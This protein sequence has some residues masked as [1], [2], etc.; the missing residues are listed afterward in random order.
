MEHAMIR[1]GLVAFIVTA[2]VVTGGEGSGPTHAAG[3]PVSIGL[4]ADITGSASAYGVSIR[5]G[6][7]LASD[8]L[9]A[10]GGVNGHPISLD[11]GD[12]ASSNTQ[13]ISLYQQY[14]ADSHVLGIIGPTLSSEAFKAD[15]IAQHAGLPVI[16]TSN[17]VAGVTAMGNY[18]FRMSLGEADVVPLTIKTAMR[19]FHFKNVAIL[20]GNDNAFTIGDGQVFAAVTKALKLHVLD[21]ET[22]A[23]GDK[24]FKVQL[25]KIKGMHPDAIFVGA[26]APE[27]VLIL[28]QARQLGL[29]STVRII[30]GN[31]FNSPAV[32]SGAGAAAEGTI[33]GT[34]WFANSKSMANQRFVTAYKAKYGKAPDQFAAQA[35]DGVNIMAAGIKLANT[36]SSRAAVRD[37]LTKIKNVPVVTGATGT[38]S[39]LPSRDA[40]E[41]GTVQIIQ[42]GKFVQ[43]S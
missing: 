20:Y 2:G 42:G 27:A 4:V 18:I 7:Q 36:V 38:F 6:A 19:H 5:N 21:T 10:A 1:A 29:P 26:L 41:A 40:G 14:I 37:A 23:T 39:F 28:T 9:N 16:A 30:G 43:Y 25:S 13:V 35:F 24:D 31:G 34:A 8:M 12:A 3:S 22:F 15:P 32:I 33:E 11:V 17:T